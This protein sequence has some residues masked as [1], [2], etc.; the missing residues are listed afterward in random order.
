MKNFEEIEKFLNGKMNIEETN[1]FQEKMDEDANLAL[2]VELQ[3]AEN[4]ALE[5]VAFDLLSQEIRALKIEEPNKDKQP[6]QLGNSTKYLLYFV[7]IGVLLSLLS[8]FFYWQDT[9]IENDDSI[10]KEEKIEIERL[11]KEDSEPT[12]IP[13]IDNSPKEESK[14]IPKKSSTKNYQAIAFQVYQKNNESSNLRGNEEIAEG[15]EDWIEILEYFKQKEYKKSIDKIN[16]L[17]KDAPYYL[18]AKHIKAKSLF[19]SQQ[20][21][22]ASNIY[23]ELLEEG[24]PFQI[25]DY[26]FELLLVYLAHSKR[27]KPEFINLY[28]KIT[29]NTD[30]TFQQVALELN[31]FLDDM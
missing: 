30:H 19:L 25:Y 27:N 4:D 1:T 12:V 18:D 2:E 31:Q 11:P 5:E 24:D 7:L 9:T 28:K 3:R 13:N 21:G 8:Y 22:K 6:Q 14:E 15:D 20:F 16:E 10:N 29:D 17:S 23:L 26:E